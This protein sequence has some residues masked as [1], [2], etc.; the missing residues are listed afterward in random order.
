MA[1]AGSGRGALRAGRDAKFDYALDEHS[2]V[3]DLGGYEGQWTSDVVAR[4]GCH[5]QVFEPVPALA[6][7]IAKR[8]A[9]SS[10]VSVHDFGLG[11]KT[12]MIR[13][14]LAADG[15]SAVRAAGTQAVEG[16]IERAADWFAREAIE[17]VDLVK[18]NIE[19]GEYALIEHLLDAGLISRIGSLQVQFHDSVPDARRRMQAIHERL[20]TTHASEWQYEFV[21][22]SW[23]LRG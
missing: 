3:L 14:S 22:E 13:L 20:A 19:G 1:S 10:R 15:T 2:L 23:A 12:E 7:A 9:Q 4:Y 8:F 5:V 17:R 18:I 21:W 11:A 16:R 6:K